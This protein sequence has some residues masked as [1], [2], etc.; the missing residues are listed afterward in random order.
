L[1]TEVGATRPKRSRQNASVRAQ[2]EE[3]VSFKP[4]QAAGIA[5]SLQLDRLI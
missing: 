5:R 2:P 1:R 4:E 3:A